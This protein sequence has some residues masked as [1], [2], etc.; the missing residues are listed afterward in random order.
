MV[1]ACDD[2]VIARRAQE[3]EIAFGERGVAESRVVV[4]RARDVL[5]NTQP[6][7]GRKSK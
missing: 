4:A 1:R 3:R 6:L 7:Q 5:N 2:V